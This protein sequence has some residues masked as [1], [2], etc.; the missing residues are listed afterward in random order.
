MNAAIAFRCKKCSTS[1]VN[2][3]LSGL[4]PSYHSDYGVLLVLYSVLLT[5]VDITEKVNLLLS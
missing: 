4:M 3:Q 2:S 1:E 5:K